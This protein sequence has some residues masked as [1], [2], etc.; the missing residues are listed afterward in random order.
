MRPFH[1]GS[2]YVDWTSRN[3][4]RCKSSWDDGMAVP[5]GP[6][7]I[8]NALSAACLEDGQVSDEI[9]KRMGAGADPLSYSWECPEKELKE[10]SNAN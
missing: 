1:C 2:Q 7:E 5:Y 6:C 10:E 3:C 4:D 8:D 9:G